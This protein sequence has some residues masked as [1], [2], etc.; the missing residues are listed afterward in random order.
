MVRLYLGCGSLPREGWIN[1]DL[2]PLA[3]VDIVRDVLRGLP[4]GDGTVDEIASENFLEHIPQ[5][6]VI[7]LMNEMHRV[8]RDRGRARHLI[9]EAGTVIQYQDPTHLSQW[10]AETFTYF[11]LNHGRNRVYPEIK[12]WIIKLNHT[13]PNGLLDVEMIKAG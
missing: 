9:P 12:P 3:G 10:H 1:L 4:F 13:V 11:E 2:R 7:W 8:L 5:P 6:E